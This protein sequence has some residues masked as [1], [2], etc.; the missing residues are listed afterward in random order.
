ML[1]FYGFRLGLRSLLRGHLSK[2]TIALLVMPVNYWRVKE[3]AMTMTELEPRKDDTILDIGSPK[4][5]SLYLAEKCGA[6][7]HPTDI[8]DYF[9]K[10]YLFHKTLL[11]EHLRGNIHLSVQ[12]GRKVT[13]PDQSFTK[14]Y[15]ISVVEHIPGDGDSKCLSEIGRVLKTGGRCVITVPFAPEGR[16]EFTRADFYWARSSTEGPEKKVFFQR[17][18]DEQDIHERLVK[19]S[20]LCLRK[21]EFVGEKVM[22]NSTKE[23]SSYLPYALG[24]LHP[25]LSRLFLT[26][27]TDDWRKLKKPLCAL[28]V[29][30][31][32]PNP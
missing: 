24:P 4:L 18:Y 1:Y 11:P 15:S 31:K 6:V 8:E 17:R 2:R 27:S 12:D 21:L 23:L 32:S 5:F 7:V 9:I 29:L 28:V 3:Y 10:E 16:D 19:P 22:Q 26:E 14:V 30:E 25:V 13:F 20:G